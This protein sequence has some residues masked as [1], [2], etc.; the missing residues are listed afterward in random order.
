MLSISQGETSRYSKLGSI[1]AQSSWR[2]L[3]L[4]EKSFA[5]ASLISPSVNKAPGNKIPRSNHD[6]LVST[7]VYAGGGKGEARERKVT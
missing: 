2:L 5:G 6:I 7:Q 1:V 4:P 3:S